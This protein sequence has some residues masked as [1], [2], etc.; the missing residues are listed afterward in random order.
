MQLDCLIIRPC[1]SDFGPLDHQGGSAKDAPNDGAGGFGH[2]LSRVTG[3]GTIHA[4]AVDICGTSAV[5]DCGTSGG[6]DCSSTEDD[7]CN[8]SR[9]SGFGGASGLPS[10]NRRGKVL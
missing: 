8:G 6:D 1:C 10:P 2:G 4:S 5:D 7:A 3:T 9:A